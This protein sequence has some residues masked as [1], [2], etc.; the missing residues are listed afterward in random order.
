MIGNFFSFPGGNM[1][2]SYIIAG[3]IFLLI[4]G[5]VGAE[6]HATTIT[7]DGSV[8][9]SSAGSDENGSM[10]SRVMALDSAKV[11]RTSENGIDINEDLSV[12]GTGPVLFTEFVSGA[13]KNSDIQSRCSFLDETDDKILAE[14]SSVI[15]G[16]LQHGEVKSSRKVGQSFSDMMETNG[17]GMVFMGSQMNGNRS[18]IS[19]GFI[20]GNMTIRDL[21]KNGGKI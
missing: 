19:Q 12:S 1:K 10:I 15:S 20:S 13:V 16:I 21:L 2:G 11:S 6:Y 8:M 4:A 14:A 9:L 17:S 18:M 5:L 7:S 3:L